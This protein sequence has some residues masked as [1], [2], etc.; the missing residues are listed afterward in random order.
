MAEFMSEKQAIVELATLVAGIIQR[1]GASYGA[2]EEWR[3]DFKRA[4]L[5]YEALLGEES[6]P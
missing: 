4:V 2:S 1:M 3:S 6:K 5:I